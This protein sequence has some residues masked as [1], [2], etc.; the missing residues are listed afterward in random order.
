MLERGV[1]QRLHRRH[2]KR[3]VDQH[4]DAT[5]RGHG[6]LDEVVDLRPVGDVGADRDGAP[7]EAGDL[8]GHVLES[9]DGASRQHQVGA[10]LGASPRQ[11]RAQRRSD[12]A[13]HDHLA[14][15]QSHGQPTILSP[16]CF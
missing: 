16:I 8:L 9:F 6:L 13:D 10:L 11:R 15:E 3:V 1:G 12:P 5:V 4:V 7:A 2:P 14:V